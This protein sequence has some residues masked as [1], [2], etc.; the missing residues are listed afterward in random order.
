M[1]QLWQVCP[2]KERRVWQGIASPAVKMQPLC[3]C[4]L[5]AWTTHHQTLPGLVGARSKDA[6]WTHGTSGVSSTFVPGS[7]MVRFSSTNWIRLKELELTPMTFQCLQHFL[8]I[9]FCHSLSWF[10]GKHYLTASSV[11]YQGAQLC[12]SPAPLC[13]TWVL[14]QKTWLE[15]VRL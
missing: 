1:H 15:M 10:G 13:C 3:H 12:C 9:I 8:N 6:Q 14:Q 4:S 11:V 7:S 5:S 2:L